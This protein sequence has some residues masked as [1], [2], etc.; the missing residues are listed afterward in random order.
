M[1][2][3]FP[4][5][6]NVD[7]FWTNLELGRDSVREIPQNR[8]NVNEHFDAD[9]LAP[10][11][12]YSKWGGV[13]D[14]IDRFDPD[15]FNMSPREARL[16][17]PQHRLFLMEAW[18]AFEDAGY[19]GQ[20]LDGSRCSVFVGCAS[21][22]YKNL[23]KESRVP[24]EGYTF[25]GN[26]ASILAARIAY[27]LNLRGPSM[28]IDTACSASLVAV[29]LACEA[30][31][32]GKCD[33]AL[34]GGVAVLVTPE[35]HI[36]GSKAGML[37]PRGKCR[38]FDDGADGF[39]PGEG[40]GA[41][42]LKRL[43]RAL[44]DGDHVHG[45]IR[46]SAI[47]QDG[48]TNGITA[49]SGPSQTSLELETYRRFDIDPDAITYVECHGTG[50]KLGD[51]IE[52]DALA[53]TFSEFTSRRGYCALGSVKSNIGH[54]L[55]AAGVAG[56]VKVL[57][58]LR[59]KKI[60]P[61]LHVEK[62]NQHLRLESSPFFVATE[63]RPWEGPRNAAISSFGFSGT[64]AH[65]VVG[66]APAPPTMP[67][68]EGRWR[69]AALS[70]RTP[71][72]LRERLLDLH[73][74]LRAHP[75]ASLRDVTFTLATG[76]MHLRERLAFVARS[77]DELTS[78][79]S[80]HLQ[81]AKPSRDGSSPEI[82]AAA[83][84]YERG[85]PLP[86]SLY[87][88]ER[89]R[90][91]P[92]P[93]YPFA[94]DRCWVPEIDAPADAA[95]GVVEKRTLSADDPLFSEHVVNGSRVLPAVAYLA[96]AHEALS[97]LAG[98]QS[99]RRVVWLRPLVMAAGP[100]EVCTRL[101]KDS[102]KLTFEI[103]TAGGVHC[104]GEAASEDS[105]RA[106]VPLRDIQTRCSELVDAE[107]H[108]SGLTAG[109]LDYGPSFRT[110]RAIRR[111]AD[112]GEAIVA[113]E[114]RGALASHLFP[115]VLD[116]A[117][118][119]LDALTDP[120][121]PLLIPFALERLQV[122]S[123]L[124]KRSFA[125]VRKTGSTEYDVT[126]VDE[127]GRPCV[128]FQGMAFRAPKLAIATATA[129][130]T[131]PPSKAVATRLYVPEWREPLEPPRVS[132]EPAPGR[133]VL[134]VREPHR[135]PRDLA[136]AIARRHPRDVVIQASPDDAIVDRPGADVVYF[137]AVCDEAID[138]RSLDLASRAET[139]I[140][141]LFRLIKTLGAKGAANDAL[142]LK[143]VTSDVHGVHRDDVVR[144][145]AAALV[146]FTK[147]L[148]KERPRWKVTCLDISSAELSGALRE[149]VV[150]ALLAEPSSPTGEEIALRRGR[151]WERVLREAT[152]PQP[153]RLVFRERG[154]YVILG[155]AGGIGL[156]LGMHLAR[157]A[158]A[159]LVLLGRSELDERRRRSL[160]TMISLGAEPLYLRVDAIDEAAMARAV[161]EAKERFGAIHGAFH[162]AI[163][164]QDRLV[165]N[166]DEATLMSALSPK[167]RASVVLAR[168]LRAEP[169]DFF[170][171]FSSAQSFTGNAGQSNYSAGCTFKDAL[172][173]AL[174]H[175]GV[176]TAT[177]NWGY[178]GEVGIV[179][180]DEHRQRMT[181][182]GVHSITPAEGM[183]ALERLLTHRVAQAMPLKAEARVLGKFRVDPRPRLDLRRMLTAFDALDDFGRRMLVG[184][185]QSLGLF[186]RRGAGGTVDELARRAGIVAPHRRL[187]ATLLRILTEA[188]A[189]E[190]TNGRVVATP[191]VER[192][193]SE[194]AKEM[195]RRLVTRYPEVTAHAELLRTC[196]S[197]YPRVLRGELTATDVMFPGS[198][199][200]LVEAIYRGDPVA[201][202]QNEL[203]A[204]EVR[205]LVARRERTRI[206]EIGAGTGGTSAGVLEAITPFGSKVEYTYTD[207][208][209]GF[210]QHG[211]KTF[212][213]NRSW[214]QFQRL[215][216]ERDPAQQGF[217]AGTY[218]IVL[219]AN[220]LHATRRIRETLAHA[221]KLL[222]PGGVLLLNETTGF[223]VF[224][225][226]TFGLLEGWWRFE[227]D[228]LRV[229]GSPLVALETWETLLRER[230]F[231]EVTVVD[232]RPASEHPL[233]SVILTRLSVAPTRRASMPAR[234]PTNGHRVT[235]DLTRLLERLADG[236]LSPDE[237][238]E[239]LRPQ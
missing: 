2:G 120:T 214:L 65:L 66:E 220:V 39:V 188:G 119:S 157:V 199:M 201:E 206:L 47:N 28:A 227:D 38:P 82:I 186:E 125:H 16:T 154:T 136:L 190:S 26:D 194:D 80:E 105:S 63:V 92:L 187:F 142:D 7:E 155:G 1:S 69:V 89:A 84:A 110:V 29:H 94:R 4:D 153:D 90:R 212:G 87:V 193:Q 116:G 175:Q 185:L 198:S 48:K 121:L 128:I 100:I 141:R 126:I 208:S 59:E 158:K 118:Q 27:Y 111:A 44:A 216:I 23:L 79:I 238:Y 15:F 19:S 165:Q 164:L 93:T 166:M 37:S 234:A 195:Q 91:V 133:H 162:S 34:A 11:K 134:I 225:T 143:V 144:P 233:Q 122:C 9:P 200:R 24:L 67:E 203:V 106:I 25:M 204:R 224:A 5:A 229:P 237:A 202:H 86:A 77:I 209:A 107:T 36:L 30:L 101:R 95:N 163:V 205:A 140:L 231:G 96:I 150:D 61:S 42:V 219:A 40:V 68:P 53:K 98:A 60:A 129:T 54:A 108:Y 180:T 138:P 103:F 10:N 50:T 14:D 159:R 223:N 83:D 135:A 18:R 127:A 183:D 13:L 132:S 210:L 207:L 17:D 196:V 161:A 113:L 167:I 137:L 228:E 172:A 64:N 104:R 114:R 117:L 99:L 236:S 169:L 176:P 211:R 109:G 3:R 189:L 124:P 177:V 62:T 171:F 46:A 170:A 21:G 41:L 152:V 147:S 71:T 76:R 70:A 49:P 192:R 179:A 85:E 213:T 217:E 197:E 35:L 12:T 226:L 115:G 6:K 178:W 239:H 191:K 168:A 88:G 232:R 123:S 230:G 173:D 181:A 151:R 218:D 55:T 22:D 235:D 32:E 102:G 72:A 58:C 160:D 31:R 97:K 56:L 73:A 149:H 221:T 182:L 45:V 184:A 112:R 139:W 33:L 51:P 156:E 75:G 130:A 78:H 145:M 52:I 148:A 8:W 74:W 81:G 146:G 57:L 20:Q 215:D 131:P 222:C 43:D 174:R